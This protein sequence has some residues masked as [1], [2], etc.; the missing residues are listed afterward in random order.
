MFLNGEAVLTN[1]LCQD[2]PEQGVLYLLRL[3]LEKIKEYQFD[4]MQISQAT[5]YLNVLDMLCT[6]AQNCYPYHLQNVVSNDKLYGA[7]PKFVNEINELATEVVEELLAKM[8]QLSDKANLQSSIALDLFERIA[9]RADLQDDK[10]FQLALNL[11][12]LSIKNRNS[13]EPKAH[14]KMLQHLECIKSKKSKTCQLMNELI[15]RMKNKL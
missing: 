13:L 4:P 6:C 10:V 14:F 5:I 7:D 8:K 1:K 3:L 11:W 12:N 2:S 9:T 15:T